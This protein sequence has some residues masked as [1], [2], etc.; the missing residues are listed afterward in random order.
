LPAWKPYELATRAELLFDVPPSTVAD[1]H[2]EERLA[3]EAYPTQQLTR[4][5]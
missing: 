2:R 4:G 1:P 5:V 3:M